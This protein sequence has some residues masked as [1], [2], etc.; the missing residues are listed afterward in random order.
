MLRT[1]KSVFWRIHR[2]NTWNRNVRLEHL[3][4]VY[5]TASS[6]NTTIDTRECL[7]YVICMIFVTPA[8][9]PGVQVVMTR[10]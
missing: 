2:T 10:L 6:S 4:D 8:F 5:G 3:W 7:A 9:P 1:V